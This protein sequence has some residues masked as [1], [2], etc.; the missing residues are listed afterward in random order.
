LLDTDGVSELA[1]N[2]GAEFS[3]GETGSNPDNMNSTL[4]EDAYIEYDFTVPGTYYIRVDTSD[5]TTVPF[6]GTY[7]LS[8][9]VPGGNP[10]LIL[11]DGFEPSPVP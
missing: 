1:T 5:T 9:S 11:M 4:I 7:S 10:D 2:S 8:V 3:W 6:G